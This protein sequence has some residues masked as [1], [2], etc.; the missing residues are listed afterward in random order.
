MRFAEFATSLP[1]PPLVILILVILIYIPLGM[2]LDTISIILLTTP[3]VYPVITALGYDGIW[4]GIIVILMCEVALITPP[5]AFNIFV[6]RGVAPHIPFEQITRGALPFVGRDLLIV[7][8]LIAFP[9]IALWL[10]HMM[11]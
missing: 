3:I 8:I 5:V 11:K 1:V 9:E 4:F 7:G 6:V 2:L 10:P